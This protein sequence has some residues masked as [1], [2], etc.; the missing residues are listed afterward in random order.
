MGG[1]DGVVVLAA[2]LCFNPLHIHWSTSKT[3]QAVLSSTNPRINFQTAPVSTTDDS[4][5]WTIHRNIRGTGPSSRLCSWLVVSTLT[6]ARKQGS[7]LDP[8]GEIASLSA[9]TVL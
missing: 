7:L 9:V 3:H 4:L 2:Q 8:I 1:S 6:V 5:H